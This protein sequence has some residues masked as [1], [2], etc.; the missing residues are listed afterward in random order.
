MVLIGLRLI[1]F[2]TGWCYSL[3]RFLIGPC[4]ITA[5]LIRIYFRKYLSPNNSWFLISSGSHPFRQLLAGQWSDCR[6][7]ANMQSQYAGIVHKLII[8]SRLS[9]AERC[10]AEDAGLSLTLNGFSFEHVPL[11]PYLLET[12]P[13]ENIQSLC[14]PG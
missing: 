9:K 13:A 8:F 12:V 7:V 5:E 2:S 1:S 6:H 14:V 11:R 3:E 4:E 10:L